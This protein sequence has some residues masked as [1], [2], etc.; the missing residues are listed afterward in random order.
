MADK[1]Q[2]AHVK[3]GEMRVSSAAADVLL[4]ILCSGQ[5]ANITSAGF[6]N[7]LMTALQE[8]IK[9]PSA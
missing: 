4:G 3:Q 2:F 5:T 9:S 8:D 6:S 7:R 1:P